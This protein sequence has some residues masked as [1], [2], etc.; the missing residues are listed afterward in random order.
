MRAREAQIRRDTRL[1]TEVCAALLRRGHQ[2]KFHAEGGSMQPNLLDGDSVL[3]APT[4]ASQLHQGEL[5][6]VAN[7]DGLRVHRISQLSS[8]GHHCVTRSDTSDYADP[9]ATQVFG[10]VVSLSRDGRE[11]NLSL[12]QLRVAHPFASFARRIF[13]GGRRRL[14]SLFGARASLLLLF[15]FTLFSVPVAF[16]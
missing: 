10:K 6:L 8:D 15:V 4:E 13:L 3:V 12:F 16:A 1:F 14:Q 11:H 2:V 7:S 9:A 5:T